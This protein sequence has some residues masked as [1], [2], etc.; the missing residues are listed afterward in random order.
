[1]P[2][3]QAKAKIKTSKVTVLHAGHV[4]VVFL[5]PARDEA[6]STGAENPSA[7]DSRTTL[8]AGCLSRPAPRHC[9]EKEWK[10]RHGQK[11]VRQRFSS[12]SISPCKAVASFHGGR[13]R[14]VIASLHRNLA[15]D[16]TESSTRQVLIETNYDPDDV[17]TPYTPETAPFPIQVNNE[18]VA[19]RTDSVFTLPGETLTL[20]VG[21]A[22]K[23]GD[24]SLSTTLHVTQLGPNTWS[25]K[26]P[27]EAGVYPVTIL[28]PN[29]TTAQLN[30]FVMFRFPT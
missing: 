15:V 4:P 7:Y 9:F 14:S 8:S 25:W 27:R 29:K 6:R 3:A 2:Q 24:Y 1:M 16:D 26:A 12:R 10:D 13:R 20:T 28:P 22:E 19:Y 11:H 5:S 18:Q 23:R 30:V 17:H 21:R